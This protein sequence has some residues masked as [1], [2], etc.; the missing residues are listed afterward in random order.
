MTVAIF[1]SGPAAITYGGVDIGQTKG[2]VVLK[3]TPEWRLFQPDQSTGAQGAFIVN[4]AIELTIPLI[5]RADALNIIQAN[6]L[7]ASLKKGTVVGGGGDTTLDADAAAEATVIS[8][9][10]ETNFTTADRVLIDGGKANAEIAVVASVVAGEVTLAAPGLQFAHLSGA[11][12]EEL[13]PDPKL[14][15]GIGGN[16]DNIAFA[17]LLVTPTDGSDPIQVYKALC[18]SEPEFSVKKEEEMLVELTYIGLEDTARAAG[19]RL[20]SI[21]DQSVA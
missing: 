2:D 3:Y 5:P 6:I 4:E 16:R 21:G 14:R 10:S 12:M 9:V 1:R 19:D 8:V 17:A 13:D 7:P 20:A 11:T 18:T 15:L